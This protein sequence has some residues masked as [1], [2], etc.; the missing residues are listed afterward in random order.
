MLAP[1]IPPVS[2]WVGNAESLLSSVDICVCMQWCHSGEKE[3]AISEH[4]HHLG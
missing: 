4:A 1:L 2:S 3:A